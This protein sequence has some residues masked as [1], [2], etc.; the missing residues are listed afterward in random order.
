MSRKKKGREQIPV[1]HQLLVLLKFLGTEGTGSANPDLR[2]IFGTGCLLVRR[3]GEIPTGWIDGDDF[4]DIDD[5]G[6]VPP[7]EVL[8]QPIPYGAPKDARRTQLT[9]YMNEVHVM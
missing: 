4:S 7:P 1:S 2:D 8:N 5:E 9:T 6:R 3:N